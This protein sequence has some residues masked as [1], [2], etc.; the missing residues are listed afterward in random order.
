MPASPTSQRS[1]R[2]VLIR[3]GYT[4]HKIK[5]RTPVLRRQPPA[6]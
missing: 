1:R 6:T 2:S 3:V 4:C 5:S